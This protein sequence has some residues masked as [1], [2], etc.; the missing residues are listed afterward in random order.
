[1][2]TNGFTP[3]KRCGLVV[4]ISVERGPN[5]ESNSLANQK[6]RL[7][8]RL[9]A[10]QQQGENWREV[11]LYEMRAVSGRVS[12]DSPEMHRLRADIQA[13]RVNVVMVTEL[14][15]ISR[16]VSDFLQFYTFTSEHGAE[17]VC[18]KQDLDST[19]PA[20]KL[21]TTVIMALAEFERD[22]VCERNRDA[23][24]ARSQKGFYCG[25]SRL[26]GYDLPEGKKGSLVVNERQAEVVRLAFSIYERTGSIL[27]TYKELNARGFRTE[28]YTSR[29]DKH[30]VSGLF[31][32]TKTRW[33]L[34][35]KAY[36][37]VREVNKK[38]KRRN[39]ESL[40]ENQRYDEVKA[41]WAPIIDREIFDRVQRLM[42]ANTLS[43]RN[44]AKEV[45]H[46]YVFTG[47]LLYCDK[48]KQ[49]MQGRS[50]TSR[51]K[52]PYWYYWCK[53]CQLRIPA[54]EVEKVV[55]VRIRELAKKPDLLTPLVAETNRC[56]TEELPEL[57]SRRKAAIQEL[58]TVSA[59]ADATFRHAAALD[60]S[61]A[62]VFVREKLEALAE[63]RQGL[64]A[65]IAELDGA[66]ERIRR[67]AVDQEKVVAAINRFRVI[68][69]KLQPYQRK[70]L[71]RLVVARVEV[72]ESSLRL[73]FHGNPASEEVFD[74][75]KAPEGMPLRRFEPVKWLR[76]QDSNLQHS[77]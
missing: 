51:L 2:T 5:D 60:G 33:L 25:G 74:K 76:R 4:R 17:V 77:G 63:R 19:T 21:M 42:T 47:G 12:L 64:E 29:R 46:V 54:G 72:S 70:E 37:G 18:L 36:I 31:G 30:H 66:V 55:L 69:A 9:E 32:Y 28:S 49:A 57:E 22:Q 39:P 52:R 20:G 3:E 75:V 7:R 11:E 65:T 23:T 45:R 62:S 71:I 48:C 15:R 35:N 61:T 14:S 41:S 26:L 59:E 27:E 40:P 58:A 68:Y 16:S 13:G 38:N 67:T 73:Q 34:Q 50:G 44:V 6:Q 24:L 10:K 53:S 1:V 8:A 43:A 56:L